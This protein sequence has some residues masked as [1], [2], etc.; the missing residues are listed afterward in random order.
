[1]QSFMKYPPLW[2]L[3]F[4]L[5]LRL[6]VIGIFGLDGLYGQDAFAY[7]DCAGQLLHGHPGQMPCHDFY[8]PLGYPAL[9]AMF[10]LATGAAV[11]A[12]QLASVLAGAAIAPLTYWLVMESD[13]AAI[14]G[15]QQR[16]SALAAGLIAA[17]CG[18]LLIASIVVMSDAAGLFWATLAACLL[19]RWGHRANDHQPP[20]QWLLLA[21]AAALGLA[22]VT[23]WIYAGL[24]PSFVAFAVI[25]RHRGGREAIPLWSRLA[26]LLAAAGVVLLMV[27]PQI[28]ITQHSDAPLVTHGW[29]TDWSLGNAVRSSFDNPE[30]HFDFRLPP[31]IFYAEPLFHPL[32]LFPLLTGFVFYGAW[33]LRRS[34]VLVLLGGWLG[35]LGLYLIGIPQENARFGLAMFTPIAVLAG[36]GICCFTVRVRRRPRAHGAGGV[37]GRSAPWAWGQPPIHWL[38]LTA[39]LA[40]ALPFTWRAFS[41]LHGVVA[42]QMADIRY[43]QSQVPGDATVVTFE[44]SP[45]LGYY[46][47][48]NVVDLFEQS[49]QSLRSALCRDGDAYVYVDVGKIESQWRARSPAQN[50]RWLREQIGLQP[51]GAH[52]SWSLYRVQHCPQ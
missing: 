35:T 32:F 52:G 42:S 36:V 4:A 5:A 19:L 11:R 1:M 8:W 25:A 18:A 47:R 39:S 16:N 43:L 27:L 10:M 2:L 22:I 9:A 20:R 14:A 41:R 6:L 46:T 50:F 23:R 45:A 44:L 37:G 24:L 15:L 40:M 13:L 7:F 12:A 49:P 34:P 17:L 29:L 48:L 26:P 31:I 28:Y 21:A 33:Q 51:S 3:L 38:L 30:G